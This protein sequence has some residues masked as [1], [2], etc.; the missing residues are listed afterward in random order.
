M[1]V[2]AISAMAALSAL[3]AWMR[4]SIWSMFA[5]SILNAAAGWF[6]FQAYIG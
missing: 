4:P 5:A 1:T 3:F 6:A 2:Y